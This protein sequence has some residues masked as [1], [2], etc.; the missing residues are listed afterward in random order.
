MQARSEA[1]KCGAR[2]RAGSPCERY[3]VP[4]RT[5]CRLHGGRRC[6]ASL[7]PGISRYKHGEYSRDLLARLEARRRWQRERERRQI[8][9]AGQR[10][11]RLIEQ[12]EQDYQTVLQAAQRRKELRLRGRPR[13]VPTL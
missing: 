9:K 3:P 8:E 10:Y 12:I 5:R 2:T 6:R 4:G 7:T 1:K 11:A 13:K